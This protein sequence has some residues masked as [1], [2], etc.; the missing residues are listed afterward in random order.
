MFIKK[1]VRLEPIRGVK[2]F[3]LPGVLGTL[4]TILA[5]T[6]VKTIKNYKKNC[7]EKVFKGGLVRPV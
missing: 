7:K 3:Q 1:A 5:K 2:N 4:I 6:S